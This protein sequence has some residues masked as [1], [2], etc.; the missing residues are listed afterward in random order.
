[1]PSV[2]V[3]NFVKTCGRRLSLEHGIMPMGALGRS[4]AQHVPEFLI[5]ARTLAQVTLG[6]HVPKNMR[7]ALHASD[8]L[9]LL[10]DRVSERVFAPCAVAI[11][12]RK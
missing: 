9:D 4:I 2:L 8:R 6:G 11:M 1:M 12:T 7:R 5:G 3:D 10:R